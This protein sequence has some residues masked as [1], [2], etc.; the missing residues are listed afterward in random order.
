VAEGG[1]EGQTTGARSGTADIFISYASQD[2][3]LADAVVAALEGQRLKCWIAPR[4]VTPGEF[5]ADAIVRAIN[6]AMIHRLLQALRPFDSERGW[7]E[8]EPN[9]HCGGDRPHG[10]GAGLSATRKGVGVSDS[11]RP[12][13]YHFR[14]TT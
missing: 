1:G 3:T 7:C 4:D 9:D 13:S 11:T 10:E 2:A 5:Y 14:L 12:K 8:C 6:E